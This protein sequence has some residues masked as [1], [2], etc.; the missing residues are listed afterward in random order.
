MITEKDLPD[1]ILQAYNKWSEMTGIRNLDS[2][3]E[4]FILNSPSLDSTKYL[5]TDLS[6][7]EKD[8][9]VRYVNSWE[10]ETEIAIFV[11]DSDR[12]YGYIDQFIRQIDNIY[13]S[14]KYRTSR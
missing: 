4:D 11:K 8:Y 9:V 12:T 1:K 7:N 13:E 10:N 2:F 6:Y 14:I 5:K 3:F